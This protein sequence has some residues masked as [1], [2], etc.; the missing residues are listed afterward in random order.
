MPYVS[1]RSP[2]FDG[3][4]CTLTS[5]TEADTWYWWL[6]PAPVDTDKASSEEKKPT[7]R[8]QGARRCEERGAGDGAALVRGQG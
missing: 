6:E 8:R 1:E 4:A 2:N 3:A 5:A 7:T